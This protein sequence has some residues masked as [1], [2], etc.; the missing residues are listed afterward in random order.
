MNTTK[1]SKLHFVDLAGSERQKQTQAAGIFNIF[2]LFSMFY[3]I[4]I[5]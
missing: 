1:G 2:S 3:I 4:D 5:N